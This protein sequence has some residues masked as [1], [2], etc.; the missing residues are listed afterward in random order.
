MLPADQSL[1]WVR[2]TPAALECALLNAATDMPLK[3][4]AACL[5]SFVNRVL[6]M[7][8]DQVSPLLHVRVPLEN[9]R[10]TLETLLDAPREGVMEAFDRIQNDGV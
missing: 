10:V 8:A 2:K 9:E 6:K 7:P 4:Y 5:R 3:E 1:E